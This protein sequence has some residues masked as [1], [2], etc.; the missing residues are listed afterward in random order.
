VRTLGR[1][2]NFQFLVMPSFANL[3][4]WFYPLKCEALALALYCLALALAL[5]LLLTSLPI[6][7]CEILVA[8]C[9]QQ[10]RVSAA[11]SNLWTVLAYSCKRTASS[12]L[13]CWL[14]S[15][16]TRYTSSDYTQIAVDAV[17]GRRFLWGRLSSECECS[18]AAVSRAVDMLIAGCKR[19]S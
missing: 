14:L 8:S 16:A 12:V 10:L 4:P 7:D 3:R 15:W 5:T 17:D 9:Q 1:S 13:C 6:T 11:V 19:S 2:N 18:V